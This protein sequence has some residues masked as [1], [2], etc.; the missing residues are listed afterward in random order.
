MELGQRKAH[1]S[2]GAFSMV[3]LL[4]TVGIIAILMTAVF[5]VLNPA[6]LLNQ[7]ADVNRVSA[8]NSLDK[9]VSLYYSDA[10]NSPS[11]FFMGSSSVV[12]I[13]IPDPTAPSTGNDCSGLGLD[14]GSITY[15]CAAP[16]N[17]LKI[18]GTGWLPINFNTY[19][20]GDIISSLPKDPVNT[21]SSSKF[22]AYATDGQGGYEF[23]GCP[24]SLKYASNTADFIRGTNLNL[25]SPSLIGT[26][27]NY[28]Y[29]PGVPVYVQGIDQN[30][31]NA[32]TNVLA[33]PS[34]T[35]AGNTLVIEVDW[36]SSGNLTSLS[37]SQGNTLTQIGTEQNNTF[38]GGI[39]SR[40]YYAANIKGGA[41]TVTAIVTGSPVWNELYVGEYSGAGS[42]DGFSITTSTSASFTSGNITT[43]KKNDLLF[44]AEI[45]SGIATSSAGW[46]TRLTVDTNVVADTIAPL[47]GSY[48]FT[49]S[50][51]NGSIAWIAAFKPK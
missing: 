37:D 38:S 48:A 22:Y 21:P 51:S 16:S 11:T 34:S 20:G 45:D 44:G 10:I 23:V 28:A 2:Q 32:G 41:D 25:F 26:C 43:T 14:T 5:Y 3:E 12:Y 4:V 17:Y 8:L 13:S 15:H 30:T 27:W 31:A 50:S 24:A 36:S 18:D 6:E 33:I 39:E 29:T 46:N 40:L 49:G 9:A 47:L 19:S 42:L 35:N 7:G 1:S